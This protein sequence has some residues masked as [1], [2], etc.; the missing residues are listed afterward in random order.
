MKLGKEIGAPLLSVS[1]VST[2]SVI[3]PT[4][5]LINVLCLGTFVLHSKLRGFVAL[6][7]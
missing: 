6:K 1:I 2:R 4:A 7:A 5:V 3:T